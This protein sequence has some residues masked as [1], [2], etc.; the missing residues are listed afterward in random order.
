[1]SFGSDFVFQDGGPASA[2]GTLPV[3]RH[4]S[5]LEVLEEV[6]NDKDSDEEDFLAQDE[7][8][9]EEE[10]TDENQHHPL[11]SGLLQ[12]ESDEDFEPGLCYPDCFVCLFV[13]DPQLNTLG[14][15]QDSLTHPSRESQ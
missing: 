5:A 7:S 1:M 12:E 13:G 6:L 8:D 3:F 10:E 15:T 14:V 2:I 4:Y 11:L 9:S